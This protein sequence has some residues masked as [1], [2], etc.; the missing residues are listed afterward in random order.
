MEIDRYSKLIWVSG[1][2]NY[3]DPTALILS[4]QKLQSLDLIYIYI[5]VFNVII[6]A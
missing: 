6:D 2:E 5:V 3:E 4:S 1:E